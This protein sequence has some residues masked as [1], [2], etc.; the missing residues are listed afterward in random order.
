MDASP[1][2][3]AQSASSH[4]PYSD[5]LQTVS[6]LNA[7][8]PARNTPQYYAHYK[9]EGQSELAPPQEKKIA[10]LPRK[11]FWFI[12]IITAIVIAAGVGGGIGGAVAVENT[13]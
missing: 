9:P 2:P 5:G 8:E 11:T 4:I 10:G 6:S 7:Q 12:V 3:V 13:R 1:I